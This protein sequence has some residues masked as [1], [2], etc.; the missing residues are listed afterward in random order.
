MSASAAY[1]L[2]M[3][4]VTD[5]NQDVGVRLLQESVELDPESKLARYHLGLIYATRGL[6]D[7]A[8]REFRYIVDHLDPNDP[9]IWFLLA[10]QYDLLGHA[11][12]ALAAYSTTLDFDPVCEKAFLYTSRLLLDRPDQRGRALKCAEMAMA[13]RA[14]SCIVELS[15]FEETLA[16]ARRALPTGLEEETDLMAQ[17]SDAKI[18]RLAGL[19]PR[20]EEL[21][22][23]HG[24][25]CAS[26]SGYDDQTLA[27]AA[28]E[29][30]ADLRKL[31]VD[32]K[33]ALASSPS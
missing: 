24:I 32:L 23:A 15:E 19:G 28:R 16:A 13:L 33:D 30:G 20:I 29:A 9:A 26:C 18:G 6:H 7:K 11:D 4:A 14:E 10:R 3:R 2:I 1:G 25:S 12:D 31:E 5:T 8:A 27:V 17:L 22:K 21:L